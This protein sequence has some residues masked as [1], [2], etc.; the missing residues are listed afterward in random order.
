MSW[1]NIIKEIAEKIRVGDYIETSRGGLLGSRV[2]SRSGIISEI[3][4]SM[5]R[6]DPAGEASTAVSVEEYDLSLGYEG[7]VRYGKK[8]WAYLSSITKVIPQE[9]LDGE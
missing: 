4:I 2:T 9:E 6:H 5:D 8:Y 1:K 3:N 7:S